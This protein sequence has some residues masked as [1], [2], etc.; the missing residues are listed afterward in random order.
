MTKTEKPKGELWPEGINPAIDRN[1]VPLVL[2]ERRAAIKR[3]RAVQDAAPPPPEPVAGVIAVV[4]SREFTDEPLV[5]RVVERLMKKGPV[6]IVS[7]GAR[8]VDTFVR[9]AC[10]N[11]GFHFCREDADTI[12]HLPL[13]HHFGE[14]PADWEAEPKRAGFIRNAEMV[15]HSSQVI[16]IFA[17]GPKSGG[18]SDTVRRARKAG[19]PVHE[20]H[21]GQ[22]S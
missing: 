13:P 9:E 17:P 22:W 16:A 4:G 8:G 1:G 18:T 20:Y 15:R 21:E 19:L 12:A 3:S 2:P 10:R 7:G 6:T 5:R 11:L 14:F